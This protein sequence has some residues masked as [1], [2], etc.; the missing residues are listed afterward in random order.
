MSSE[1]SSLSSRA[2]VETKRLNRAYVQSD[3]KAFNRAFR[4]L[5]SLGF[6]VQRLPD[7]WKYFYDPKFVP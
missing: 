3:T 4:A 2:E 6:N 7:G 1:L 5:N